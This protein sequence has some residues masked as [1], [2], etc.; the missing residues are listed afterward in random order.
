MGNVSAHDGV[1][2]TWFWVGGGF[3]SPGKKFGTSYSAMLPSQ[4]RVSEELTLAFPHILAPSLRSNYIR[5]IR[6]MWKLSNVKLLWLG[7]S[8]VQF[9]F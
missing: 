1:V 3:K 5:I 2:P 6:E 9:F 4:Y 8:P 7:I